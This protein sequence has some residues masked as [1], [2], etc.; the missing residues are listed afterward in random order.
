[1][2]E[3]KIF[4]DLPQDDPKYCDS[5]YCSAAF[6]YSITTN[7]KNKKL[8]KS[9]ELLEDDSIDCNQYEITTYEAIY[10]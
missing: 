6:K 9:C 7:E 8:K 5:S 1:L 2:I 3:Q 10:R 4:E